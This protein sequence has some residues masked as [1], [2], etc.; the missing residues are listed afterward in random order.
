MI[1]PVINFPSICLLVFCSGVEYSYI[2]G[3]GIQLSVLVLGVI[4]Q[5]IFLALVSGA[6]PLAFSLG[7][8]AIVEFVLG[9]HPQG[10]YFTIIGFVNNK[11]LTVVFTSPWVNVDDR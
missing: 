9:L 11:A 1:F 7:G 10:R 6:N 2:V 3:F 8:F 4:I 5:L